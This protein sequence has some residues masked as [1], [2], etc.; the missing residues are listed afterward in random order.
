M[1]LAPRRGSVRQG[2]GYWYVS[3]VAN[4]ST[5]GWLECVIRWVSSHILE[6]LTSGQNGCLGSRSIDVRTVPLS[7]SISVLIC[8]HLHKVPYQLRCLY[9]TLSHPIS[10][11]CELNMKESE[12]V[13]WK[14][15]Y[16]LMKHNRCRFVTYLYSDLHKFFQI[17]LRQ[18]DSAFLSPKLSIILNMN[19]LSPHFLHPSSMS[20]ILSLHLCLNLDLQLLLLIYISSPHLTKSRGVTF[21]ISLVFSLP[22]FYKTCM[23]IHASTHAHS[24]HWH[25]SP[26][27]SLLF[28][29]KAPSVS[30]CPPQIKPKLS[31]KKPHTP[32]FFSYNEGWCELFLSWLC[33]VDTHLLPFIN[34]MNMK[35]SLITSLQHLQS[36]NY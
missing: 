12:I 7:C 21:Y 5:T 27:C 6:N 26:R 29:F 18:S 28:L 13:H 8:L 9:F 24:I 14:M 15:H 4:Q 16:L 17:S 31:P 35:N 23:H 32:I 22:A 34:K 20:V 3:P 1:K 11:C 10:K 36:C 25:V 30:Y 33:L 19:G 2:I